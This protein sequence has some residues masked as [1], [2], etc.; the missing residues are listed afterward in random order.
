MLQSLLFS[1]SIFHISSF[2]MEKSDDM[3][4]LSSLSPSL[5]R[6]LHHFPM[7]I[8]SKA[9]EHW[10]TARPAAWRAVWKCCARWSRSSASCMMQV[11]WND[12]GGFLSHRG[13]HGYPSHHPWLVVWNINFIFPY[14]GNNHPNWLIFFRGVQTTNQIHLS[15]I[16]DDKPTSYW[17][18]PF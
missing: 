18:S 13:S 12:R 2:F 10:T 1:P 14:I 4:Q 17:G 8:R 7:A 15:G 16:F 9:A 3:Q 11:P 5:H 6:V